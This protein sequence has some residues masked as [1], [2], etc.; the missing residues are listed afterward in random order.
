MTE[1]AR[2][3]LYIDDDAGIRRLVQR[4]L[5]RHGFAVVLADGGLAGID[6]LRREAFDAVCLDHYMPGIDGLETLERIRTIAQA[7]PVIFV[8]GS[9]EAGVAVAALRA[10]AADYVIKQAGGEFLQLL[11]VAVDGAI[12][13]ASLLR[14]KE[15]AVAAM[16]EA[17]RRAEEL[18]EQRALLLRE[19][20]H[21]VANS[22]QMIISLSRLQEGTLPP[23]PARAALETMRSRVSAFAQ[24]YRRLYTSDDVRLVALDDYLAGLVADL[25]RTLP[26]PGPRIELAAQPAQI[27]TDRAVSLGVIITELVTN[28]I[29]YAYPEGRSGAIRLSLTQRGE[30][31]VLAVEDDGVGITGDRPTGT[32]M[33]RLIIDSLAQS[34]GG[35]VERLPRRPGTRVEVRFPAEASLG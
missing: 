32:G 24:V 29:K 31:L 34:I 20:N 15:R 10:G 16:D 3:L 4:E 11:R 28:A 26:T 5:E 21:R 13:R 8:T 7:P 17:R 33:G 22:L 18:A 30:T 25:D 14:D 6:L 12:E 19:V 9:E 35:E 2:R 23:G 27:A 1:A